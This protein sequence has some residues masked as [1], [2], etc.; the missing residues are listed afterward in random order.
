MFNTVLITAG[1]PFYSS[2]KT[3]VKLVIVII[4]VYGLFQRCYK[5]KRVTLP[6]LEEWRSCVV[7]TARVLTSPILK[8]WVGGG[9]WVGG[10]GKAATGSSMLVCG[11]KPPGRAAVLLS[12]TAA[13][14]DLAQ[15]RL[16][17]G[18]DGRPPGWAMAAVGDFGGKRT[19]VVD[20]IVTLA[21]W[22]VINHLNK[23]FTFI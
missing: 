20:A 22:Q 10:L 18:E 11:G 4:P 6:M 12:I 23:T 15:S 16:R 9:R 14:Y 17:C 5:L 1:H 2:A 3:A 21:L 7:G 19:S 13:L 8:G